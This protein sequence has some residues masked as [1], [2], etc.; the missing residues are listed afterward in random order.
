MGQRVGG[1]GGGAELVGGVGVGV[2][3][4]DDEGLAAGARRVATAARTASSS[5]GVRMRPSGVGALGDFEAEVAGDD[6]GEAAGHA[7]G[8]GP[9]A[10]AEL[11]DVAEALGGDEAGAGE[12]A[13]E[14][15][16][17]G[18][19]GAV[20]D[21]VDLGGRGA[22]RVEGGEDAEGL[23]LGGGRG[24]GQADGAGGGVEEDEVGEGAAHVDAG[25]DAPS[26]RGAARSGRR[27]RREYLGQ[28]EEGGIASDPDVGAEL[29]GV[30]GEAGGGDGLGDGAVDEEGDAVGGGEG[31]VDALLDEEGGDA[32]ALRVAMVSRISAIIEGCRPSVGSSR[33]RTRGLGAERAGDGEHLLLAAGEGAGDLGQA[34]A[35]AGEEREGAVA[36]G[37]GVAAGE[38]A[39]SRFSATVSSAK[40]RRPWGTQAMP[41]RGTSW[42]GRVSRRVASR[43]IPPAEEGTRPMI[44]FK[45]GRLAG[46]VA[47]HEAENL[48]G[49]EG[50]RDPAEHLH[51]AVAGGYGGAGWSIRDRGRR[52]G[53]R[54]WP[55]SLPAGPRRGWRPKFS[56]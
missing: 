23:V 22:G 24:L 5:R 38:E 26:H 28:E 30:G 43:R 39:D 52:R 37:G 46:A 48:A 55:G 31:G 36:G 12:A 27:L 3:E 17:G 10:A 29:R 16:V 50:E 44:A 15:G 6:R 45:R 11:E 18:G 13:L 47:A 42:A 35:E 33:R 25:D 34:L 51:R 14:D 49:A 7:V 2:E 54:D 4:V 41:W 8:V 9:G 19:G 53:R 40:R 56:T 32:L 21:E 20:D 1:D